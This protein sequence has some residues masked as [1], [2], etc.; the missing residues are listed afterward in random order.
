MV[1]SGTVFIFSFIDIHLGVPD[2]KRV[3]GRTDGQTDRQTDKVTFH[4]CIL[5]TISITFCIL[6]LT[7]KFHFYS[8]T[9]VVYTRKY[10]DDEKIDLA[11]LMHLHISA[12][13]NTKI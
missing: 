3:N 11:I 8:H 10:C 12:P 4:I 5:S 7:I 2:L 1:S 6:I 13:L 9:Y